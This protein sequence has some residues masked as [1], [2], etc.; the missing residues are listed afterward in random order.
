M[1]LTVLDHVAILDFQFGPDLN[2]FWTLKPNLR[3]L[4]PQARPRYRRHAKVYI[5]KGN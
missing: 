5:R 3:F 4:L 2:V 1:V